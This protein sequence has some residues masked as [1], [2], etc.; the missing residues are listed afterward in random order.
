MRCAVYI[1][2]HE[3]WNIL[4]ETTSGQIM[5]YSQF[6]WLMLGLQVK[7]KELAHRQSAAWSTWP[8]TS[9]QLA[10]VCAELVWVKKS[11]ICIRHTPTLYK[12]IGDNVKAVFYIV[13][14]ALCECTVFMWIR[15]YNI[16]PTIYIESCAI[17]EFTFCSDINKSQTMMWLLIGSVFF[18]CC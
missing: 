15:L 7:I 1:S 14:N 4:S 9:L 5:P 6:H 10:K 8:M 12:E 18:L 13:Y 16:Y 17:I 3:W 2:L 11:C